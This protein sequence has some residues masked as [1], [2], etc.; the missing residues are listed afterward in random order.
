MRR[1]RHD[2]GA[3]SGH[4]R[5][6]SARRATAADL[7]EA[8]RVAVD[9]GAADLLDDALGVVGRHVEEGEPLEHADV[10]D[11]LAVEAGGGA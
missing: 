9:L 4:Q 5:V 11:R 2:P 10:A 1:C 7:L 3:A 8:Q 6:R